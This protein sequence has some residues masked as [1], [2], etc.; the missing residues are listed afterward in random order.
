MRRRAHGG[1]PGDPGDRSELDQK[2]KARP[3][4]KPGEPVGLV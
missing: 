4:L 1:D 3:T 2:P